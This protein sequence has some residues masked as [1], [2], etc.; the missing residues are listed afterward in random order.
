MGFAQFF[1][2]LA[3][4]LIY[5]VIVGALI[6]RFA[7]RGGYFVRNNKQESELTLQG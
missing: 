6:A 7:T 5:V 3:F 4:V 2:L 1:I